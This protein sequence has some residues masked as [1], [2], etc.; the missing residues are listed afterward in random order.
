MQPISQEALR[1]AQAGDETAIAAL[2]ARLMPLID[3][4]SVV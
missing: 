4:K 2:I 3:R 1:K